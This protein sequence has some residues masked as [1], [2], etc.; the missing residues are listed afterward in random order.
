VQKL[1]NLSADNSKGD[2]CIEKYLMKSEKAFFA[3]VKKERMSCEFQN[4]VV[5]LSSDDLRQIGP[6]AM[7]SVKSSR[8]SFMG[9]SRAPSIIEGYR[10]DCES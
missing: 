8:D 4:L 10:P 2:L 3:D 9:G 7:M 6:A 5:E 1:Q